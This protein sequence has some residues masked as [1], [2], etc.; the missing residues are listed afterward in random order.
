[1]FRFIASLMFQLLSYKI[2]PDY[3]YHRDHANWAVL[4]ADHLLAA[5]KVKPLK[6]IAEQHKHW[7]EYE[8]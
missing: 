8:Q 6:S 7:N 3:R 2:H 1:M 4:Q 5:L